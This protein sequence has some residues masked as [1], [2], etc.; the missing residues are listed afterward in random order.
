MQVALLTVINHG[1]LKSFVIYQGQNF[2][3]YV[4]F[5]IVVNWEC[6]NLHLSLQK[7]C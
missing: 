2:D 5:D 1:A 7:S 4:S 3:I 6:K